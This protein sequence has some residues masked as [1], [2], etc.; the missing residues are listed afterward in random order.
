MKKEAYCLLKELQFKHWWYNGRR[1]II[2]KFIGNDVCINNA[3]ILDIGSGYGALVPLLKNFGDIDVI[4]P[5]QD[6]HP[7]LRELGARRI[8]EINN[9]P[10]NYP[11]SKYDI[12]T[13]FDVL[14]H[15]E[16]DYLALKIIKENLLKPNGRCFITVPAYMWLWTQHDKGHYRR[17]TKKRLEK[18]MQRAGFKNTRV[19]YFMTFLF[20]LAVLSRMYLK[21]N[22]NE[23]TDFKPVNPV[24]NKILESIFGLET[25]FILRTGFPYG[26][27][28]IAK[29]S[30]F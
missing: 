3:E 21:I 16:D 2:E 25:N 9:F 14:E 27:S 29:G 8:F 26:L 1:K 18:L 17:Y 24:L 19:S 6:A 30:A 23:D 10:L 7:T 4:E 15:I 22:P 28:I 13:M 11:K 20:P 12:V 5:Y